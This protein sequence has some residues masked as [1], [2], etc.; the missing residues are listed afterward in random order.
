[1]EKGGKAQRRTPPPP[2]LQPSASPRACV[3]LASCLRHACYE[4]RTTRTPPPPHTPPPP[5]GWGMKVGGG[6]KRPPPPEDKAA[7]WGGSGE[8]VRDGPHD[9]ARREHAPCKPQRG[10]H[11]RCERRVGRATTGATRQ[12]P[13]PPCRGTSAEPRAYAVLATCLR[14]RTDS[15]DAPPPPHPLLPHPPRRGAR[16]ARRRRGDMG[17]GAEDRPKRRGERRVASGGDARQREP[18]KKKQSKPTR[19]SRD[20]QQRRTGHSRNQGAPQGAR[21]RGTPLGKKAGR[22][23]PTP[24]RTGGGRGDKSP[25]KTLVRYPTSGVWAPPRCPYRPH[26]SAGN[27][28]GYAWDRWPAA[29][30]GTGLGGLAN[31]PDQ[32][33][34]PRH[35]LRFVSCEGLRVGHTVHR[36]RQETRLSRKDSPETHSV[37]DPGVGKGRRT[38]LRR[39]SICTERV[40][41][42]SPYNRV[43][44]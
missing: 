24:Q 15:E 39:R 40:Q 4:G 25:Q 29:R 32:E 35:V 34:S 22:Q 41:M 3:V 5:Q 14:Q 2:P 28:V 27:K 38:W 9:R 1:M 26:L 19:Q 12:A 43:T 23:G 8:R 6:G 44:P 31:G 36:G 16:T 20:R 33:R 7:G 17:G 18:P 11:R 10:D 13:P 21:E 30:G 42:D 37:P